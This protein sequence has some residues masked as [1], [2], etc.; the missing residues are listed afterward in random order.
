[1]V[2]RTL[3]LAGLLAVLA[4]AAP[5]AGAIVIANGLTPPT[6]ANIVNGVVTPVEVTNLGCVPNVACGLPDSTTVR[7]DP[8]ADVDIGRVYATSTIHLDGGAMEELYGFDESRLYVTSSANVLFDLEVADSATLR[9]LGGSSINIAIAG[10]GTSVIRGG[11]SSNLFVTGDATLYFQGGSAGDGLS[12]SGNAHVL[13][14]GGD[15]STD[16]TFAGSMSTITVL[17]GGVGEAVSAQDSSVISLFGGDLTAATNNLGIGA[18][19]SAEIRIGGSGFMVDG[20]PVGLGPLSATSGTLS[21]TLSSGEAFSVD[22]VHNGA[23]DP[24]GFTIF[25]I[26]GASSADGLIVLVPEPTTAWL[27]GLGVAALSLRR[28]G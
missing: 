24:G 6:P 26:N 20:L 23:T 27:L 2:N 12:T 7:I 5:P 13:W 3:L 19:D 1:M 28:R 8:G 11:G 4:L 21:G 9:M 15:A 22:F 10:D 14:D 16:F 17:S 25:S 18:F